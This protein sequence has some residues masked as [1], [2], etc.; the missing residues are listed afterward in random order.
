MLVQVQGQ[1]T[2]QEAQGQDHRRFCR[3]RMPVP[4]EPPG[5][6]GVTRSE[7]ERLPYAVQNVYDGIIAR[8]VMTPISGDAEYRSG[9]WI[10]VPVSQNFILIE[11][12]RRIHAVWILLHV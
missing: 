12:F 1:E 3:S 8:L 6:A 11:C 4:Q 2:Q 5:P 10:P 7:R 9:I